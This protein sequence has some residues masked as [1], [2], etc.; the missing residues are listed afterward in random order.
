MRW[1]VT[2]A[3][4]MLGTDL[5]EVLIE[6]GEDVTGLGSAD[7]DIRDPEAVRSAVHQHQVIVNAAGW[8]AVDEAEANEATAF[9]VN[10]VGAYNVTQAAREAGARTVQIS[11]YYVFNG[12]ASAPYLPSQPQS[13][14]SAYGRTKAAGEW[15]VRSADPTSIVVRTA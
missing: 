3:S 7:L 1:L 6:H 9:A 4:G 14:S 13:P 12:L 11:T 5:C 8:T 10:A 2:G 15:A